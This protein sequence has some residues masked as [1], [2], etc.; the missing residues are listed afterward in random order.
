M[1]EGGGME[2]LRHLRQGAKGYLLVALFLAG[3]LLLFASVKGESD[4]KTQDDRVP[5]IEAK[6]SLEKEL[7]EL[8]GAMDGIDWVK[9]SLS[10]E[11]GNEYV[12]ENGK[13]TLVL[14][15]RVRGV[16]VV[17]SGGNDPVIKERVI[18]LVCA[19]FDLP[20]RAVSVSQ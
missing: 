1:V 15:G 7:A 13:N 11:S 19:L 20:M 9:V 6:R 16:A 18:G 5:A 10:L 14:A 2:F 4:G 3:A 17:C 12:W 8:I